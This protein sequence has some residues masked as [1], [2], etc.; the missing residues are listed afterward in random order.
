MQS[1][2]N[3]FSASTV[4]TSLQWSNQQLQ[5]N[6]AVDWDGDGV[7]P[8]SV[9]QLYPEV[10]G[11]QAFIFDL[12]GELLDAAG[13]LVPIL[14][15]EVIHSL[16]QEA[17][18]QPNNVR[19]TIGEIIVDVLTSLELWSGDATSGS[20]DMVS[21]QACA[22]NPSQYVMQKMGVACN[23]STRAYQSHSSTIKRG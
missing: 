4:S 19:C 11:L 17:C 3:S 9:V 15:E 5:W 10:L 7:N 22:S 8:P 6:L 1:L 18:P 12:I 14:V 21:V 23:C 13:D 20:L 2:V 16:T